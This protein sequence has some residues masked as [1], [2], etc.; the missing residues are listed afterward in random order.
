MGSWEDSMRFKAKT[1]SNG[2]E[3]ATKE[4]FGQRF[5]NDESQRTSGTIV[6]QLIPNLGSDMR[7]ISQLGMS[8]TEKF[9][10]PINIIKNPVIDRCQQ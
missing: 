4:D 3:W 7:S 8:L 6:H 9:T 2:S 1:W 10:K 5:S